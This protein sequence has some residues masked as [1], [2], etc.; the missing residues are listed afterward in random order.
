LILGEFSFWA[1]CIFWL[2]I[3]CQIYAWKRFSPI[4]WAA[5][6]DWWPF[7]LLCRSFLVSCS[8]FANPFS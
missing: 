1:T 7:L 6:S 8:S 5:S 3:P 4:L 2:L